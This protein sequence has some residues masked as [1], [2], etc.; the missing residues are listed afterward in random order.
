MERAEKPK[1][2]IYG[3]AFDPPTI[4][5]QAVIAECLKLPEFEE[6]WVM[7]CGQRRDKN[8]KSSDYDRLAM[9]RLMRDEVF[10]DKQRLDIVGFELFLDY[11]TTTYLTVGVLATAYG[12]KDLWY[13]YGADSYQRMPS[14]PGG[15]ELQRDLK[16]IV[17]TRNGEEIEK[18]DG[19]KLVSMAGFEN[20]SSTTVREAVKNGLD[21]SS[22]ICQSVAKYIKNH[23]L[24]E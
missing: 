24:Y 14:W 11:P 23:R 21:I 19:V 8:I 9:L 16:V 1:T 6:V 10:P 12:N 5:H 20:L 15:E 18:R 3:G 13:A 7:P 22:Y 4:A 17:F 2:L